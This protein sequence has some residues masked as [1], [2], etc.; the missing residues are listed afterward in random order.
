MTGNRAAKILGGVL[1]FALVVVNCKGTS[2]EGDP[3]AQ[4]TVTLSGLGTG[5]VTGPGRM[6]CPTRCTDEYNF[7]E[8]IT[9]TA[10]PG[11]NSEFGAWTGDCGGTAPATNVTLTDDRSCDA[12]FDPITPTATLDI[13]IDAIGAAIGKVIGPGIDCGDGGTDCSED[14]P[15]NT[16]V[17]LTASN[18]N[19][20]TFKGWK[21]D[22]ASY[23]STA[24]I[25]LLMDGD[26][27]CEASFDLA[28]TGGLQARG[29]FAFDYRVEAAALLGTKVIT[30]GFDN[31]AG[32]IVDVSN[33]DALTSPAG[34][35]FNSCSGARG[36]ITFFSS[37]LQY[38]SNVAFTTCTDARQSTTTPATGGFS[39]IQFNGYAPGKA[40][41]YRNNW[42]SIADFEFGR[43]RLTD[44]SDM[45]QPTRQITLS[46]GTR[47]CPF[48]QVIVGDTA[49]VVGR[50]GVAGTATESCN[51]WIGVWKVDLEGDSVLTFAKFGTKLRDAVY[52]P[53]NHLYVTD[54]EEDKVYVVNTGTMAV[55]GSFGVGDGP[56]G[57]KLNATYSG[58]WVTNWNS[59][60]VQYWNLTNNSLIDE[61]DSGG[62][63]PVDVF[64]WGNDAVVLNYGDA[65]TNV[66][67]TL[68]GFHFSF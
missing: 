59:N 26:K 9:L 68:R 22:C 11:A 49:F 47:S 19:T 66:G 42:V 2:L 56:V 40:A 10:V 60:K 18:P 44:Q 43:L 57:L 31:P 36:M 39:E 46:S 24:E 34:P 16:S 32:Q 45:P 6:N 27:H 14:Y 25:D 5:S 65:G 33:L 37:R 61:E 52:A 63:H 51:D 7:D 8:T 28:G 53:D 1:L 20:S 64:A 55:Q 23:T 21:L 48:S 3:K 38:N 29:S 62:V 4:L 41:H 54:F 17:H 13:S 67:A 58:L 12:R 35:E 15:I 50:E 30:A